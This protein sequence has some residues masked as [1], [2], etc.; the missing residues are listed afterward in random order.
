MYCVIGEYLM[1]FTLHNTSLLKE[2]VKPKRLVKNEI[3]AGTAD[4]KI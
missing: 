4:N 3:V 1:L 2:N